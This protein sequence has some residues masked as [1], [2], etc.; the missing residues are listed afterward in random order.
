[1]FQLTLLS[2]NFFYVVALTVVDPIPQFI[3]SFAVTVIGKICANSFIMFT[4]W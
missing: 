2:L 1:M 4:Q 3:K